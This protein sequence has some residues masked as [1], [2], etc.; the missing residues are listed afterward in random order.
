M[1]STSIDR[2]AQ[3]A[4][5]LR[6]AH[7]RQ[8][9]QWL[10]VC[11]AAIFVMVVI[12]GITRLT[13]SG[14]SM[15]EWRAFLDA[16]PPMSEAAW[17]RLFDLY[18]QTP[19][20]QLKNAWMTL[21]D[22][23]TIFWW[24][25]IHRL[26]GRGLGFLFFIP[27]VWFLVKRRVES[28]LLPALLAMFALG[29]VQGAIGWWMVKSGLVDRPDV[30]QYRLAVHLTVA[31]LLQA[32]VFWVALDLI[33]GRI[34]AEGISPARPGLALASVGL[35]WWMLFVIVTGAFVAGTNAGLAYNTYPL[36]DGRIV[37]EGYF[38][39][40]PGWLNLFENTAAIQFNHRLVT[41]LTL[42]FAVWLWLKAWP[43]EDRAVRLPLGLMLAAVLGQFMLGIATLLAQVPVSLGAAHQGGAYV[44]FTATLWTAHA[45]R[46]YRD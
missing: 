33:R 34:G 2:A 4:Q 24:E 21:D 22:F 46:R 3:P 25:Y 15:V 17:Q 10:L 31:F 38:A 29:A 18:R 9:G 6:A 45:L 20:F 12:G 7:R 1:T 16:V 27:F 19:E 43:I 8:I 26:W 28:R 36:M 14:L 11:S 42:V 41:L 5:P 40:I 23:K 35:V 37:P 39:I 13:E 32:V 44:L 30:S